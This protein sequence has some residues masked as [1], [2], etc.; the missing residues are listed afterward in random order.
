MFGRLITRKKIVKKEYSFVNLRNKANFQRRRWYPEQNQRF[1]WKE[2]KPVRII[3]FD[4][5]IQSKYFD[6]AVERSLKREF[7][8]GKSEVKQPNSVSKRG[9]WVFEVEVF[10]VGK[11][12]RGGYGGQQEDFEVQQFVKVQDRQ[13]YENSGKEQIK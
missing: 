13:E 10:N 11:G 9:I 7:T 4:R 3:N 1:C 5:R 12:I 6:N 2:Q 8:E